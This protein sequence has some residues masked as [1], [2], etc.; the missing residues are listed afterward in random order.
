[1]RE[2]Q[3]LQLTAW[4]NGSQQVATQLSIACETVRMHMKHILEKLGARNRAHAVTI[5]VTRGIL[6]LVKGP[7]P[8]ACPVNTANA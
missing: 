8:A 3:V 6:R 5:A 2:L 4:G 1:M 7:A